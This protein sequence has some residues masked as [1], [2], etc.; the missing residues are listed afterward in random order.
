M[1]SHCSNI[2]VRIFL[3]PFRSFSKL[4]MIHLSECA[5]IV[6]GWRLAQSYCHRF[7]FMVKLL[8][9]PKLYYYYFLLG[10]NLIMKMYLKN[11]EVCFNSF[12]KTSSFFLT[13]MILFD[14][15]AF[16]LSA[17]LSYGEQIFCVFISEIFLQNCKVKD[18]LHLRLLVKIVEFIPRKK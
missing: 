3:S 14:F 7:M 2:L 5:S 9:K 17:P 4:C 13:T 11:I 15:Y 10:F 8:Q 12:V 1:F 16:V 6:S 18:T